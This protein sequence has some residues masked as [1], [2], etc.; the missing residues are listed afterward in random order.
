MSLSQKQRPRALSA[1]HETNSEAAQTE[2]QPKTAEQEVLKQ[3][4]AE[5]RQR[6]TGLRQGSHAMAFYDLPLSRV[7]DAMPLHDRVRLG[8]ASREMQ[9]AVGILGP[10]CP[11]V[12]EIGRILKYDD[13]VDHARL[14]LFA[15]AIRTIDAWCRLVLRYRYDMQATF[16]DFSDDIMSALE[17]M[18]DYG[19]TITLKSADVY[20]AHGG[21]HVQNILAAGNGEVVL[22][23]TSICY[24]NIAATLTNGDEAH[25]FFK[26]DFD[27]DGVPNVQFD[28]V[29]IDMG[30][31]DI[32]CQGDD[33]PAGGIMQCLLR[34]DIVSLRVDPDRYNPQYNDPMRVA[35]DMRSA[36]CLLR[37]L[38]GG[39]PLVLNDKVPESFSVFVHT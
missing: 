33:L 10:V 34:P 29:C 5:S 6:N 36:A 32:F 30:C 17:V 18:G 21:Y 13:R 26:V 12:Q 7:L 3:Q 27:D 25:S 9:R 20:D 11:T 4:L 38:G 35:R 24:F 14:R 2:F 8:C 16:R 1:A 31:T 19:W 39:H 28:G 22:D 15:S 37:K 23:E